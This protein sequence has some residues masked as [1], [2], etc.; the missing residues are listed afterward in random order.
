MDVVGAVLEL[1]LQALYLVYFLSLAQL[2]QLTLHP[3]VRLLFVGRRSLLLIQEFLLLL[4]DY[5]HVV[6]L[7]QLLFLLRTVLVYFIVEEYVQV[8]IE[9]VHVLAVLFYLHS[10]KAGQILI[11]RR[12]S[13]DLRL[14]ALLVES[15]RVLEGNVVEEQDFLRV[16]FSGLVEYLESI[17]SVFLDGVFEFEE[18]VVENLHIDLDLLHVLF[19]QNLV[20][21]LLV[22]ESISFRGIVFG[23]RREEVQVSDFVERRVLLLSPFLF[24]EVNHVRLV[25]NTFE[26]LE[27]GVVVYFDLVAGEFHDVRKVFRPQNRLFLKVHLEETQHVVCLVRYFFRAQ[28]NLV[29]ESVEGVC[30]EQIFPLFLDQVVGQSLLQFAFFFQDLFEVLDLLQSLLGP[31]LNSHFEDLLQDF[32]LGYFLNDVTLLSS[33]MP[34]WLEGLQGK[35]AYGEVLV[36]FRQ[37]VVVREGHHFLHFFLFGFNCF[38]VEE[39]KQVLR[40]SVFS[41]EDFSGNRVFL[42]LLL[43]FVELFEKLILLGRFLFISLI[44]NRLCH[45]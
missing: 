20:L 16:D 34:T 11:S 14:M 25:E 5:L 9:L 6:V 29:H 33:L 1:L 8:L 7:Q 37:K 10:Q 18:F 13:E 28:L 45:P 2:K 23:K 41:N 22:K 39:I 40:R 4:F 35:F 32:L 24:N 15:V 30:S 42:Q 12:H 19:L 38:L 43:H 17:H 31:L 26:H 36:E 21:V 3:V 44:L 27:L